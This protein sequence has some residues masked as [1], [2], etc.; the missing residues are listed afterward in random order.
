MM[1]GSQTGGTYLNMLILVVLCSQAVANQAV[2]VMKMQ[3]DPA[4]RMSHSA[5]QLRSQTSA[6]K[7]QCLNLCMLSPGCLGMNVEVSTPWG[8][9]G[10]CE[11]LAWSTH[12]T[13]YLT[14]DPDM[15]YFTFS[16]CS[17]LM[18]WFIPVIIM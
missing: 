5:V 9:G 11:I 7:I 1:A 16:K 2:K 13:K 6:T 12:D 8:K 17:F 15:Q 14:E 10:L 3:K 4:G 18:K